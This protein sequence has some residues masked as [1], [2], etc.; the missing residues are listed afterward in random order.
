MKIL[1]TGG[2]GFIG[3]H[4]LVNLL[5]AGYEV[6]ALDDLSNSRLVVKDNIRKITGENIDFEQ[7]S[8]LNIA[9]LRGVFEKYK[10]EAVIHFAGLK[11]V[12][13]SVINPLH[14]YRHNLISTLNLL[15][16]M[17]EYSVKKLVFS[18]SATVY[19]DISTPPLTEK[20]PTSVLNPYGR[21]KLIIEEI[22]MDLAASDEA[23]SIVSLRYFNPIGAHPSG[24]IG[25][26][27]QSNP[28]NIMPYITKVASRKLEKLHIFGG[29]YPTVDGTGVRD[30][31]HVMDLADGH[32]KALLYLNEHKG[33]TIFNLGTGQGKSV[34]ELIKTFEEVNSVLIPYEIVER[35]PGDI[36]TSYAEVE[37]AKELLN[38]TAKFNI[39]KMCIDSWCW[40][41]TYKNF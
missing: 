17:K 9:E 13:E 2:L 38:W 31:I 5:E 34:L 3:S 28:S 10:I 1:V 33:N 6:V 15:D 20:D 27:S 29:D 25:E 23:W 21:T 24:L 12:N 30:Y 19:G 36:S 40:E 16:I 22:L 18:S 37:K 26:F 8:L 41:K 35:R 14:Y 7:V 32:A 4:T 39:K 11:S